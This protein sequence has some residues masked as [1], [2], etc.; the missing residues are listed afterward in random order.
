MFLV[1]P[2]YGDRIQVVPINLGDP[3]G[4]NWSHGDP[5]LNFVFMVWKFCQESKSHSNRWER[6]Q[7]ASIL[8]CLLCYLLL[9]MT[10]IRHFK[11]IPSCVFLLEQSFSTCGL[12][13][14]WAHIKISNIY[15]TV[16]NS[17]KITVMKEQQKL[18]YSWG[19]PQH[20]KLHKGSRHWAGWEQLPEKKINKWR[21]PGSSA[22]ITWYHTDFIQILLLFHRSFSNSFFNS[23]NLCLVNICYYMSLKQLQ[24]V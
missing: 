19:P 7:N 21:R 16:P 4:V 5:R 1:K 23:L 14:L 3:K 9:I 22:G 2:H 24:S 15:L 6:A 10:K 12:G 17:S 13:P 20:E 8:T 11:C 18:F